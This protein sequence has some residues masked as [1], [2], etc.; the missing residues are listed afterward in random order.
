[1][2]DSR[3]VNFTMAVFGAG[4]YYYY[5]GSGIDVT[6]DF[7]EGECFCIGYEKKDASALYEMLRRVK[8]G[9]IVYLK[10]FNMGKK[11][12]ES[13]KLFIK[14]IGFVVGQNIKSLTFCDGSDM[15]YGRK[16]KWIKDF[17]DR[18][19][20]V[21]IKLNVEERVNNVYANTLYE[22]YSARI[23]KMVIDLL[24]A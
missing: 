19:E 14:A 12:G 13:G 9:D 7:L 22:E 15:G 4:A 1:M 24:V 17:S 6:K 5:D 10:S 20:W 8:I 21:E 18:E 2:I 11:K 23:I 3:K 16:V